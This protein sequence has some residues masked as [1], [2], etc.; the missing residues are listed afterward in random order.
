MQPERAD[1]TPPRIGSFRE[2]LGY[3]REDYDRNQRSF[4]CAGFQ[5][6]AVYRLGVWRNSI[7]FRPARMLLTLVYEPL[8]WVNRSVYGIELRPRARIGRRL[9]IAHQHGIVIHPRA[10]I[11]DDCT[12]RQGVTIGAVRSG[13]QPSPVLGDRVEVAAGAVIAG[14]VTVGDGAMIGP[15][16]VVLQNVPP[17]SVV[18]PPPIRIM[19]PPP[20]RAASRPDPAPEAARSDAAGTD[21]AAADAARPAAADAAGPDA[22]AVPAARLKGGRA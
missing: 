14:A 21:A 5:A 2:L 15:N 10:V 16:A 19:I 20:R 1:H 22:A 17:G 9:G 12:I 13:P 4:W 18:A 8:A 11:G 7:G 6:L 3:I